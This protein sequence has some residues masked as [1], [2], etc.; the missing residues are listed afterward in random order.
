MEL[1]ALVGNGPLKRKLS[2]QEEGRGL[3]HAYIL[4]G[5][6]GSGK[7][8]LARLLCAAMLCTAPAALRPCGQ[9]IPCKK[10][11]SQIHPD[12]SPICGP[13]PG[14]PITVD[15]VRELRSDAYIL[16]NEGKRKVYIF[17]DCSLLDARAQNVL[18]KVV[19]EGPAHAAFLFCAQSSAQLLPTIRSRCTEWKLGEEERGEEGEQAEALCRLLC[20]RDRLGLCAFFTGLET[21]K[22][23]REEL[24]ELLEQSRRLLTDALLVSYGCAGG[25]GL[26]GEL[27][28]ALT[29]AQLNGAAALLQTYGQQ[30][31]FNLNVGHVTGALS[32]ALIEAI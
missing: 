1:S 25:D 31:R 5:P 18:L 29:P 11:F 8:T 12:V 16:P 22:C 3:S 2:Q 27:S 15:Q 10:V 4:S 23:K 28:R 6:K 17:P 7:H 9:C 13:G 20:R 24:Q 32:A 26:S 14:K 21:A 30:L 19:E